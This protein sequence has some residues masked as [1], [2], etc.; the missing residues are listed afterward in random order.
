MKP[1][2][3]NALIFSFTGLV[4]ALII[5]GVATHTEPGLM[6][7]C[8]GPGGVAE[9]G[10]CH[11]IKWARLPITVGAPL[12]P[13]DDA[14]ALV[15]EIQIWNDALGIEA[16]RLVDGPPDLVVSFGQAPEVGTIETKRRAA[17]AHWF[18]AGSGLVA[19]ARIRVFNV[20][21]PHDMRIA[22]AHELGHVLGLAHDDYVGSVMHPEAV[23][24]TS[25]LSGHDRRLVRSTYSSA[26]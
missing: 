19:S 16:F 17:T 18:A 8:P 15:D 5:Y 4:V 14:R 1:R 2:T 22:L 6:V 3:R 20:S 25:M 9:P 7:A 12:A 26:D 13:P 10:D 24:G 11:A 23:Y 21:G